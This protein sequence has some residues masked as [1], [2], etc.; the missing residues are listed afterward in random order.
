[1]L[2]S[3]T[4]KKWPAAITA[5][6]LLTL[7]AFPLPGR[8]AGTAAWAAES[9]QPGSAAPTV[10]PA[11]ISSTASAP[12][13][14]QAGSNGSAPSLETLLPLVGG[15]LVSAGSEDWSGAAGELD[16]FAKAWDSLAA[17]APQDADSQ[18][19]AALADAG[20]G[21]TA[22][23]KDKAGQALSALAKEVNNYVESG[24]GTGN[25]GGAKGSGGTG[26]SG[27]AGSSSANANGAS[28]SDAGKQAAGKLLEMSLLVA[29]DLDAGDLDAAKRDYKAI[30]DGWSRIETPIRQSHF[31]LY[32]KLETQMALIRVA[33][34]AEPAKTEQ[35]T[36]QL[37]D[38]NSRL[39]AYVGGKLDGQQD[40]APQEG[41]VSLADGVKLL[42]QSLDELNS[43]SGSSSDGEVVAARDRL[44]QFITMWP[45]I[46]G[47]VSISS[48]SAYQNTE[49]RMTEALGYLSSE[50]PLK[51]KAANVLRS[52]IG[53]LGPI[54]RITAYSAWD[55]AVIL[56]REGLEAILVVAALLAFAG[57]A[58]NRTARA[59][60]W[61]GAGAGLVL[62]GIL[63]V[64]L[65]YAISQASSGGTR[66]LTEGITGLVA[67][68]M[69][70][71]VG[72]WLHGKS[73][74]K[75]W[76]EYMAKQV[77]GALARGSLWSLFALAG[78]AI[79]REGAE[80]AIF[81]IG[82][83]PA[84]DNWQLVLGIGAAAVI[85]TV[86][87]YCIIRFSAKLPVGPFFFT[88]ALLI[89]Y[90]VL[91]FLGESLHALQI[92]GKLPAHPEPALPSLGWLGFYPTWETFVPQLLLLIYI[93]WELI[94]R[95]GRKSN[96]VEAG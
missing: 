37:A 90:L 43:G 38:M 41:S 32:S 34:Q 85:L 12:A 89:Y 5:A 47:E 20:A 67:V 23:D 26:G 81:Y 17:A 49:N 75:A 53:E 27:E 62:S 28:S 36:S 16:Q 71:T 59:Y 51:D 69:M 15:A 86:V 79:L 74:T 73:S 84:I 13:S 40:D 7:F 8:L 3:R 10:S 54:S 60:I 93:I 44:D 21:I 24:S 39:Q 46:E 56:L 77:S 14:A 6:L 50:P 48:S 57:R 65:T 82:M 22:K 72:A 2:S 25:P 80:T 76:N 45:A 92:A 1:M 31:S 42:T 83:A 58:D 9:P 91:R 35:A 88:A 63:A 78:L 19:K 11:S 68:V 94:P 52:M 87:G 29:K 30:T 33:L 61:S 55:A 96:T 70:L 66:E 18:I 4:G 64:L 95:R